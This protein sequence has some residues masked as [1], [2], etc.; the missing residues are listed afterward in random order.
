MMTMKEELPKVLVVD[1]DAEM[2]YL[3]QYLLEQCGYQSDT[4]M[5]LSGFTKAYVESPT[6]VMLDLTIWRHPAS[7]FRTKKSS[8]AGKTPK[9]K[10]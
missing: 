3:A 6:V 5:D 1:D 8:G 4:A 10:A 2:V 9:P 7:G